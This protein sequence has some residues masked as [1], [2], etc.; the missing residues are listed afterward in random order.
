MLPVPLSLRS[1]PVLASF[2]VVVGLAHSARA[3]EHNPNITETAPTQETQADQAEAEEF[4]KNHVGLFI[5][6]LTPL[7][8]KHETSF[9][10]GVGYERRFLR[11]LGLEAWADFAIGAHERAA[12]ILA[13]PV[14]HPV[15]GFKIVAGVGVEVGGENDGEGVEAEGVFA[16][17]AGYDFEAGPVAITPE[18]YFDFVGREQSNITYGVVVGYPF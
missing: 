2:L 3:D 13:G 5:G 1:A 12:I 18:F 6:G 14:F 7:P 8:R 16:I 9:A 10:L 11:W 17:G 15:A 4:H